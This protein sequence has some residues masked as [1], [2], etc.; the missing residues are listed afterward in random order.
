MEKPNP[1]T[2]R[3]LHNLDLCLKDIEA[4]KT[5]RSNEYATLRRELFDHLAT[6]REAALASRNVPIMDSTTKFINILCEK[7]LVSRE[8]SATEKELNASVLSETEFHKHMLDNQERLR[9][10]VETARKSIG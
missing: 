6:A 1:Y 5:A 2:T 9:T 7:K 3:A 10:I 4:C 8:L